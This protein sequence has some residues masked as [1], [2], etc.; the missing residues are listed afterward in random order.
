MACDDRQ[1]TEAQRQAG[2][3]N[4]R[5]GVVQAVRPY[6]GPATAEAL[7]DYLNKEVFPALKATRAKVNDVF[8]RVVDNAPSANPL[9]YYFSTATA[10][11]DPTTGRI[12]LDA[13]TQSA[14]TVIRISQNNARLIDVAPWLDVMAGSSTEPLGVITLF[15]AINPGR[16]L[17]FDLMDMV[18]NG[19][20][21]DLGVVLVEATHPNPFVEDGAVVMAFIPG[22]ASDGALVP[23][24]NLVPIEGGSIIGNLDGVTATPQA[25]PLHVLLGRVPPGDRGEPGDT[26]PPGEPGPEGRQGLQGWHGPPGADGEPGA[27]GVGPPGLPGA[28][29]SQGQQG[30]PGADGS[31]GEPGV[32]GMQGAAGLSVMGPP[33]PPGSDGDGSG[34]WFVPGAPGLPGAPGGQGPPGGDGADGAPGEAGM[35]GTP[36]APGAAGQQGPPGRDG[37][38]SGGSSG[39]VVMS[40]PGVTGE[41]IIPQGS[42]IATIVRTTDFVWTGTHAFEGAALTSNV[43]GD[44]LLNAASGVSVVAGA[45]PVTS[46]P[47]GDV[48]I[49]ADSGVSI[50]AGLVSAHVLAADAGDVIINAD[51]GVEINAGA[52]NITTAAGGTV[53]VHSDGETRLN[54]GTNLILTGADDVNIVATGDNINMT[55][56]GLTGDIVMQATTTILATA[57]AGNVDLNATAGDV[58]LD[59]GDDVIADCGDLFRVV[60]A[61]VTREEIR[62]NGAHTLGSDTGATGEVW[63]SQ[64]AASPP[65]YS[66][67]DTAGLTDGAVTNAKLA[68][69]AAGT[70]KGRQIDAGTGVPVDLTGLEQ[71]ENIRMG[72][73]QTVST[74]GSAVDVVLADDTNILTSNVTQTIRSISGGSSGRIL[75]FRHVGGGG[76]LTTFE[77][78]AAAA[79]AGDRIRLPLTAP[80]FT[81]GNDSVGPEWGCLKYN[82]SAG[83]WCLMA[84]TSVATQLNGGTRNLQACLDI[85]E[86]TGVSITQDLA[87]S[88]RDARYTF[89]LAVPNDHISNTM[90][91]NMA[92]GTIKGRALAAGTGDPT[93]L[94]ATQAA[95]I[96][97]PSL[98]SSSISASSGTLVVAP[99]GITRSMMEFDYFF[100][101]DF[102]SLSQAGGGTASNNVGK[103]H[104][105]RVQPSAIF[106]SIVDAAPHG[107]VVRLSTDTVITTNA[108]VTA[109]SGP[110]GNFLQFSMEDIVHLRFIVRAT[111][112]ILNVRVG[113]GMIA[114]RADAEIDSA[115][116]N[117]G[118]TGLVLYYAATGTAS[119]WQARRENASAGTNFS[120]GRTGVSG[121][122]IDCTL[123]NTGGGTWTV[124][125]NGVAGTTVTGA[126]TTGN[127]MPAF[128]VCNVDANQH[129]LDVDL[130]EIGVRYATNRYSP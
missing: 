91:A 55:A 63:T 62:A 130:F 76:T 110:S 23:I 87:T 45:T 120:T 22:V 106:E 19:A 127:V 52:A 34:G 50:H 98:A 89:T 95:A 72:S 48:I 15:D 96:V 113:I 85:R 13:A 116:P 112:G 54:A 79:T 84:A 61:G 114:D 2:V 88:A 21:W 75:W 9:A 90:L 80:S 68:N 12:A 46:A 102:F 28:A 1:L 42:G 67:V 17:R 10:A 124:L 44:V 57:G 43:S 38:D 59:A 64:G 36:G 49:N 97:A 37:D 70:Q 109:G 128:W 41:V 129:A 93:D 5:T 101:E 83:R 29:G 30:P 77:H 115:T 82:S 99:R 117:L 71:G 32:P 11:A 100:Q 66:T 53:N 111:I 16:S 33:G 7:V 126:P 47:P 119:T 25:I 24:G 39:M 108:I 103:Y 20:Y 94:T 60:T 14:A 104:W 86:G 65:I 6:T 31:D 125:I 118:G 81:F 27:D 51:S 8:L 3:D 69:M 121:D 74:G 107:S 123:T 18:D 58:L 73:S 35:P 78:E 105:E 40:M 26:G 4:A 122:W 56:L 92:Q